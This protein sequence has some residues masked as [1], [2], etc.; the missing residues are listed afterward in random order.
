ME[1][2]ID[3]LKNLIINHVGDYGSINLESTGHSL[4][5]SFYQLALS[6]KN[7]EPADKL[8]ENLK[9]FHD[10]F[11]ECYFRYDMEGYVYFSESN[12]IIQ[13]KKEIKNMMEKKT[14]LLIPAIPYEH[15]DDTSGTTYYNR[16]EEEEVVK[17]VN[18][19]KELYPETEIL[20]DGSDDW[21]DTYWQLPN[22]D[23]EYDGLPTIKSWKD[24]NDFT[25]LN[26][27]DYDNYLL[28]AHQGVENGF[29]EHID[30]FIEDLLN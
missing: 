4:R 22:N 21:Y 15:P 10:C 12:L 19:F 2:N 6:F 9:L 20:I 18:R 3:V 17:I 28:V 24:K 13:L 14:F 26:D 7:E 16:M 1:K 5:S 27:P 11:T 30:I 29:N 8:M 25:W 23:Y